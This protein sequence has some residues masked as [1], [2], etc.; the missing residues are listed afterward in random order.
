MSIFFLAFQM[1]SVICGG[2]GWDMSLSLF[3]NVDFVQ[4]TLWNS[5]GQGCLLYNTTN[6]HFVC[7]MAN[8]A[9]QFVISF[10]SLSVAVFISGR[11]SSS[12]RSNL[13][14]PWYLNYNHM[15]STWKYYQYWCQ[16]PKIMTIPLQ[17]TP[18]L[19]DTSSYIIVGN[20]TVY[21]VRKLL[22]I[23]L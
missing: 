1:I 19:K 12:S 2:D 13:L 10:C 6:C 16:R 8:L 14:I 21:S 17:R 5:L 7:V 9:L 20:K 11:C 4:T 18:G 15:Y 3:A 22:Y 23:I